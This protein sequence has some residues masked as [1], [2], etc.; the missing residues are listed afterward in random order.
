[1]ESVTGRISVLSTPTLALCLLLVLAGCTV[2]VGEDVDIG[3][4][5]GD[6]F[7]EQTETVDP[8][9]RDDDGLTNDEEE[10]LGTDPDDADTDTDNLLDGW[11]YHNETATGTA[12]PGADPLHKDVYV[13]LVYTEGIDSLNESERGNLADIWAAMNV[14]NPD[15]EQGIAIHLDD[16][17]PESGRVDERLVLETENASIETDGLYEEYVPA[18]RRCV[19]HLGLYVGRGEAST[20]GVGRAPG[21]VTVNL[22]ERDMRLLGNYSV[23]VAAITH[24]LLHNIVGEIDTDEPGDHTSVGWLAHSGMV[25]QETY[26]ETYQHLSNRSASKLSTE[27]FATA[28]IS[29]T[30]GCD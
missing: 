30:A 28:D 21:F 9:D 6:D 14:S 24:E 23:R 7:G 12:L 16:D 18:D 15:G 8:N 27:G 5:D 2:S 4:I 22:G 29:D 26:V 10:R 3:T 19:Y 25:T 13:H 20:E 17:S 11:E 1:M